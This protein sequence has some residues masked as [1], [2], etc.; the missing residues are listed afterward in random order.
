VPRLR[1]VVLSLLAA[2]LATALPCAAPAAPAATQGGGYALSALLGR[3][4]AAMDDNGAPD[5]ARYTAAGTVTG[6]G[7]TGTFSSWHDGTRDR[8]DQHLGPRNETVLSLG[9][10]VFLRD[11]DNDVRELRGV[12]LRRERTERFIDDG[13]FAQDPSRCVYRGTQR[14]G[15]ATTRVVDVTAPGG[16]TITLYLDDKTA[17]PARLAYDDDDGNTTVD[18]GDWRSVGGHRFAFLTVISNGDHAFDVVQTTTNVQIAAD[19]P[20]GTFDVPETRKI[21]M[22]VPETLPLAVRDGHLYVPVQI[23]GATYQFLIDSGAASIL[24]DARVAQAAGLDQ[25]GALEAAGATRTGG[26]HVAHLADLAVGGGH[27]RNLVVTTID[28][29]A[30]THGA[31]RIDG[32]LGY[33]FF[34]SATV[35]IDYANAT[36]TFGPPGTLAPQGTRLDLEI[37]RALPEVSLRLN[38]ALDGQFV[39]DTGDA[40]DMLLYRPFVDRHPSIVQFTTTQRSSYGVGGAALSYRSDLDRLD[41]AGFPLYHT[42]VDVML[43]TRGAFADRFSAGNV[44]FG[45]LKNFVVTFD[46]AAGAL[47]LQKGALFDDG[48]Y[49]YK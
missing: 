31:F 38:D 39:V 20:P 36:M 15:T 9:E 5:I 7:L 32:V 16:Q 41:I 4:R 25:Q 35:R 17:L 34:A 12:L 49:R 10:H 47:Y 1:T 18:L 23:N 14:I 11:S 29:G 21:D 26:L 48:R 13:T 22:P 45:V 43:T 46:D 40:A 19:I 6:E 44:G 28:L 27:L 42:A 8:D 33:P 30:S 3:Y 2:A 24:V 37:D